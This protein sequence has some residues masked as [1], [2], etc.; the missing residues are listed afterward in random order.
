MSV[1]SAPHEVLE[2]QQ[3]DPT[4]PLPVRDRLLSLDVD[5]RLIMVSLICFGFG[6]RTFANDPRWGFLARQ[7]DHSE[8]K[9]VVFWD[10]IQPAFMFMVGVAMP[11]NDVPEH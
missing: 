6:L 11:L 8:W 1:A 10:I 2:Y 3:A 5:R 4:S 7:V 9:G